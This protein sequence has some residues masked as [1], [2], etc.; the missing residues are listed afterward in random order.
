MKDLNKPLLYPSAGP[1]MVPISA[2]LIPSY[3]VVQTLPPGFKSLGF[4]AVMSQP[5]SSDTNKV[6]TVS[7]SGEEKTGVETDGQ[8]NKITTTAD[9][10]EAG[11]TKKYQPKPKLPEKVEKKPEENCQLGESCASSVSLCPG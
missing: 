2:D 6:K 10:Q 11:T 8:N 3:A 7:S 9:K 5:G 1:Q 4:S